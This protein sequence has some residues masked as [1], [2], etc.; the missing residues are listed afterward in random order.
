M[1]TV[2]IR[3]TAS[4]PA[5]EV[6]RIG[7]LSIPDW[8][9]VPGIELLSAVDYYEDAS[10]NARQLST[11]ALDLERWASFEADRGDPHSR[12]GVIVT[13]R[14]AVEVARKRGIS[15]VFLGL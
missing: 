1:I 6:D 8:D 10:F 2:S 13:V 3:V 5:S 7:G 14:S 11:L 9:E 4:D 15:V 12:C